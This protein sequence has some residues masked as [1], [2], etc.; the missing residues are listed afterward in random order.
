VAW[1][2]DVPMGTNLSFVVGRVI[3]REVVFVYML[4]DDVV[5][6]W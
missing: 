2:F 5:I 4:A 1:L 3:G 6:G